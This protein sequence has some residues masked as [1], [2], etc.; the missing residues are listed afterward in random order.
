MVAG[1]KT[2]EVDMRHRHPPPA[3]RGHRVQGPR[4]ARGRRGAALRGAAQGEHQEAARPDVDVLT[5]TA[6]P[7]PRTLEMSLTGIRDLV[8][9]PDPAGGPPADPHLRRRVRRAGRWARPSA[10]SCCARARCSTSTTGS[11]TSSTA[12]PRLTE[13]VPEARIAVAHGQMDEGTPRAGRARLLGG[14]VRRAGLHHD[15]RVRHRHARR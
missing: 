8:A 12:R 4:P 11:R 7:D 14:R 3:H 10:A 13:L 5:L 1:L 9:D 2:G 15:H 6:T